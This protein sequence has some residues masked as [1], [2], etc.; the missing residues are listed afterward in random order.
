MMVT[1]RNA[2]HGTKARFRVSHSGQQLSKQTVKRLR[3]KLCP[4]G[5]C[6]GDLP[7]SG[8]RHRTARGVMILLLNGAAEVYFKSDPGRKSAAC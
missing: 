6:V 4:V 5:C 7:Q 1:L 8:P 3:R 2:K